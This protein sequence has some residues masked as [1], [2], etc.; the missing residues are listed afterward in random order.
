MVDSAQL[1]PE[2]SMG[3][4]SVALGS[5]RLGSV[6][7]GRGARRDSA[8]FGTESVPQRREPSRF[9]GGRRHLERLGEVG[10]KSLQI[11]FASTKAT[12]YLLFPEH[13]L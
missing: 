12:P 1:R 3:L 13:A 7:T 2:K 8:V 5:A 9:G 4:S 11:N 6:R 10:G